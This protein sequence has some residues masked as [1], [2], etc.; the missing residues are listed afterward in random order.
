MSRKQNIQNPPRKILRKFVWLL[1]LI[2]MV[3]LAC[4]LPVGNLQQSQQDPNT[5]TVA[6]V[7][8]AI[9]ETLT[10][11]AILEQQEQLDQIEPVT[12]TPGSQVESV[13]TATPSLTVSPTST[14]TPTPETPELLI[15][16]NTNCR[17][18]PAEVYDLIYTFM[19]GENA[20]L[21]G[22]NE[23][24]SYWYVQHPDQAN[25]ECWLWGRYTE[26][27]GR[28]TDLPVFT[29]PPSPTPSVTFIASYKDLISGGK[30]ILFLVQN[31]GNITLESYSTSVKDD[32]A[33]KTVNSS[34]SGFEA[35][36]NIPVG[37]K[38]ELVSGSFPASVSGHKI[39]AT[40]KICSDNS[41]G[42]YC[43]S[44]TIQFKP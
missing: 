14:S 35:G 7:G 36:G 43:S 28:T 13:P 16:G 34:S 11:V 2:V 1:S 22:K 25:V 29:P 23:D 30:K 8:Q 39:I 10:A 42:G 9:D 33:G 3:G 15:T 24:D 40:I 37:E 19:E 6:S 26:P 12:N 41:L 38:G 44:Q 18:G 17:Y 5:P 4:N 27:K 31:I 21:I 20:F 32:T